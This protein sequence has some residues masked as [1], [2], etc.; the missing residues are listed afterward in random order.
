MRSVSERWLPPPPEPAGA[1]E[2]AIA[3]GGIVYTA[4][5][6]PRHN[7]SLVSPGKVGVDVDA[8]QA[9]A[10][11]RL[12]ALRAL[13]AAATA[14]GGLGRITR[15]LRLTVYVAC[16][17]DFTAHSAVGDGASEA[18]AEVLGEGGRFARTACGVVSLPGDACVEVELVAAYQEGS[19]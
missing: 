3:Y 12:A 4:G 10:A 2:P 18:L 1:Y 9:R 5:M 14:V 6:T 15:L 11:A 16:A 13:S 19:A 17:P 8:E 7:G